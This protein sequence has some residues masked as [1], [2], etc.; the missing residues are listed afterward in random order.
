MPAFLVPI[1]IKVVGLGF[2][3]LAG[4]LVSKGHHDVAS[5]VGI[6]GGCILSESK[7][8]LERVAKK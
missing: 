3:A 4:W 8:L 1:I 2:G 5:G 7:P 6:V